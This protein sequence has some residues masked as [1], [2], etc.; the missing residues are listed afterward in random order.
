MCGH[1]ARSFSSIILPELFWKLC[2]QGVIIISILHTWYH[3]FNGMF[4]LCLVSF[5]QGTEL[6]K[7]Y[8]I[9]LA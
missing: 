9:I 8:V 2:E 4:S 7:F 3:K 5:R 1:C 6:W